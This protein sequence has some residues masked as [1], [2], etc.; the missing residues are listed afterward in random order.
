MQSKFS[1]VI[2][3][4]LPLFLLSNII[5]TTLFIIAISLYSQSEMGTKKS[6]PLIDITSLANKLEAPLVDALT[7]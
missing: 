1:S 2:K 3:G 4:L 7:I 6:T 5:I